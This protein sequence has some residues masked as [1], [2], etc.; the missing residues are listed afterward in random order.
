MQFYKPADC[1]VVLH[2]LLLA[3]IEV[4][5]LM[6]LDTG[7]CLVFHLYTPEHICMYRG[8]GGH[9]LAM[10]DTPPAVMYGISHTSTHSY[11]VGICSHFHFL[12]QFP[13]A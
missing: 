10:C 7:S 11:T 1:C 12:S 9:V 8:M 6:L 3:A 4:C 13:D 2:N 5:Y